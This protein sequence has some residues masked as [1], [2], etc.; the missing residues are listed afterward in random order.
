MVQIIPLDANS[1]LE[2]N[3]IDEKAVTTGEVT[4]SGK[5]HDGVIVDKIQVLFSNATSNYPDDSYV[6]QKF[7]KGD[8]T[9][10]YMASSKHQVLDF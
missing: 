10:T 8:S 3:A 1:P 4:I 5:I 9:F 7:K 6:L 2:F